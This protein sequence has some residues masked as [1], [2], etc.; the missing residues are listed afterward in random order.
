MQTR[1]RMLDRVLGL[2]NEDG[3]ATIFA[4]R[5]GAAVSVDR[6]SLHC[7][8]ACRYEVMGALFERVFEMCD[9][10]FALPSDRAST[11]TGMRRLWRA[12][13]SGLVRGRGM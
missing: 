10:V 1:Q 9:H 8:V 7:Y 11:L 4:N 12:L 5:I 13:A 3:T 2:F 6:A